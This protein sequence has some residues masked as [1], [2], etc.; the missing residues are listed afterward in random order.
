[1]PI[2]F[3]P[4]AYGSPG[5][6]ACSNTTPQ[7]GKVTI[8]S[9]DPTNPS[10]VESLQGIEACPTLVLGPTNLT[11]L[12]YYP[13][14]VTDP[15]GTLGCHTDKQV[16]VSNTGI[17]PLTISSITTVNGLDGK[18]IAL[19]PAPLEFSVVSTPTSFSLAP[20]GTPVPITVRF[21]PQ[22][23]TD[24]NP[25]APDQQTGTLMI[26]SNDPVTPDNTAALCGEPVYS[27]GARVLVVD[28]LDNPLPTFESLTLDTVN[29]TPPFDE[30]LAPARLQGPVSVCGNSIV[31][32]L[33]NETLKPTGKN[34][35]AQYQ[36]LV[37]DP[38]HY[39]EPFRFNLS[40][41]QFE[42]VVPVRKW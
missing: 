17:C 30:V 40:Q 27:S 23:L 33:D 3:Q 35:Y 38:P 18:G 24:Q 42:Q 15:T 11:G 29:I 7:T 22:I 21:H 41:C 34:P 5:Y 37:V 36:V 39:Y 26:K 6:V 12:N 16:T 19:P 20:G 14:T 31:W 9:N 32:H 4:P 13:A 2:A 8:V 1:L 28:L 10:L 25:T